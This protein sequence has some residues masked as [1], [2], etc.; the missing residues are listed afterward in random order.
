MIPDDEM[1]TYCPFHYGLKCLRDRC[2]AFDVMQEWCMFAMLADTLI[3]YISN[4]QD[5]SYEAEKEWRKA[6]EG[7]KSK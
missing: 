2:T 3:G 7:E 5:I 6:N 1:L 4:K